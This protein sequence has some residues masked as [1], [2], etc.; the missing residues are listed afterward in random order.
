GQEPSKDSAFPCQ[1]G[2]R[3]QSVAPPPSHLAGDLRRQTSP[4]PTFLFRCSLPSLV[5]DSRS[6]APHPTLPRYCAALDW[7]GAEIHHPD[8][9]LNRL[10]PLPLSLK[11]GYS[12]AASLSWWE[13]DVVSI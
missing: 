6:V 13:W 1:A 2:S 7:R 9:D 5:F 4:R 10:L 8:P 3:S 11:W 12:G